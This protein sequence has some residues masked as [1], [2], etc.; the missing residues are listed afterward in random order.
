M[1]KLLS[2]FAAFALVFTLAA[3]GETNEV[4]DKFKPGTHTATA[5]GYAGDVTVTIEL[6]KD[7]IVSVKAVGD[8]ET[9]KIGTVALEQMAQDMV[10][11]QTPYVDMVTGATIT[12]EAILEAATAA[13]ET[14]GVDLT[15]FESADAD[16]EDEVKTEELTAQLVVIGAGGAGMA[17]AISASQQGIDVVILEKMPFVGGNTTRATGGMNAAE[18]N[19]QAELKIEDSVELFISDTMKGGKNLNNPDLVDVLANNSNDAILW[20]ETLGAKLPVVGAFGGA[21]VNRIHKPE[22]GSAVGPYLVNTFDTYLADNEIEVFLG[23]EATELIVKDNKV[24]GVM[25]KSKDTNY[26]FNADAVIVATGGFGANEEMFVSYNESLAGFI[27]TNTDAATGDGILM[28]EAIGANLVDMEQIQTHPTVEQTTK[29]MITEGVRGDGAILV[30]TSGERFVAELDTRDVVSAAILAQ[31]QD[32]AY[33]VFDEKLRNGQKA[34]NSYV[35]KGLTI[36]SDTIEGLASE[37]GVDSTNL[38]EAVNNWNDVINNGKVDA[39]GRTTGMKTDIS[40]GPFYAIK[41][42]PG[43]HHTMGGIEINTNT[44]V[45]N[46][47]GEVIEGLFAAGEVT[48]GVHGANRL[49]GNAVTDIVVFGKI[50]GESAA[51][52]IK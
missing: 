38:I 1:K 15:I 35:S 34:V 28:A 21:S 9:D 26:V 52:Y 23:T 33:L 50:A 2:I 30:N 24:V 20:L 27:N 18:T 14:A 19:Q 5:T 43:V 4:S 46:T 22:G 3:C 42:A 12:S 29:A 39:F 47:N 13:L 36:Q 17:S 25:A 37:L 44:E 40:E 45:I 16:K 7:K 10:D 8:K 31:D 11:L 51:N 6:S 32:F 48:G 49:G 41:V